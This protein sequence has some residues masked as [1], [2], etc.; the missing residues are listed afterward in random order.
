[1]SHGSEPLL[2]GK[3]D[4]VVTTQNIT[5]GVH[6]CVVGNTRERKIVSM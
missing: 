2:M 5:D 3:S 1:M 6:F 4:G